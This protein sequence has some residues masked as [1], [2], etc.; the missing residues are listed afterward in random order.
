MGNWRKNTIKTLKQKQGSIQIKEASI[1][2]F[3]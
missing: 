2:V 1:H 3:F